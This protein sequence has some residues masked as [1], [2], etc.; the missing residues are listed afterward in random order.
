MTF[1]CVLVCISTLFS[2]NSTLILFPIIPM[3]S[4]VSASKVHSATMTVKR[5]SWQQ[6]SRAR[7]RL[8]VGSEFTVLMLAVLIGVWHLDMFALACSAFALFRAQKSSKLSSSSVLMWMPGPIMEWTVRPLAIECG[9]FWVAMSQTCY[10]KSAIESLYRLKRISWNRNANKHLKTSEV[11]RTK[12]RSGECPDRCQSRFA[13]AL[14]AFRCWPWC[15]SIS[16]HFST[17]HCWIFD[18]TTSY[19][20]EINANIFLISQVFQYVFNVFSSVLDLRS[21]RSQD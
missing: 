3:L 11:P 21:Y 9:E 10:A 1:S 13:F 18:L 7:T 12:S 5:S 19:H 2:L 6:R 14:W 20:S 16:R 17:S 15:A 8:S 4:H